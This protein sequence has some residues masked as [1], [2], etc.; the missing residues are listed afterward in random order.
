MKTQKFLLVAMAALLIVV[1]GCS[2][3]DEYNPSGAPISVT[4]QI[5]DGW[6]DYLAGNYSSALSRFEDAAARDA[7]S[8]E[9]YLGIGWASYQLQEYDQARG[10]FNNV[11]AL[12]ELPDL[13]FS[14]AMAETLM[15]EATAGLGSVQYANDDPTSALT[16]AREVLTRMPTFRFR[17]DHAIDWRRMRLLEAEAC[18]SLNKYSDALIAV[19]HLDSSLYN[20]RTLL[21]IVTR[22]LTVIQLDSLSTRFG[23]YG[24]TIPD[25]SLVLVVSVV[26]TTRYLDGSPVPIP[27]YS[28]VEGGSSFVVQANPQPAI[29]FQYRTTYLRTGDYAQFLGRLGALIQQLR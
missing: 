21:P 9:S 25:P 6:N 10:N 22:P 27:L 11:I 19:T 17:H 2:K 15:V 1:A 13:G 3:E 20:D 18:I 14:A 28:M 26:D 7:T 29:G 12:A 16:L 24:L 8:L 23:Q 4:Q 5:G